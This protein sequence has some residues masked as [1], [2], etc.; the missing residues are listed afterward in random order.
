MNKHLKI[1]LVLLWTECL[2]VLYWLLFT[3][4][5]NDAEWTIPAAQRL[6]HLQTYA[7]AYGFPALGYQLMYAIPI[8]LG[9]DIFVFQMLLRLSLCI[10]GAWLFLTRFDIEIHL[11]TGLLLIPWVAVMS[12]ERSCAMPCFLVMLAIVLI[13][14]SRM[15]GAALCLALCYLFRTE[16]LFFGLLAF[17]KWGDE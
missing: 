7:D 15:A 2:F 5:G 10:M 1:A 12:L 11:G 9:L 6:I 17:M 13:R 8:V 16:Y 14:E 3:S 4:G